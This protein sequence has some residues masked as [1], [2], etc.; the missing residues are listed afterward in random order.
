MAEATAPP[1]TP[2]S[3]AADDPRASSGASASTEPSRSPYVDWIIVADEAALASLATRAV[4][5]HKPLLV[6]LHADWC[7]PCKDLR[8]RTLSDPEVRRTLATRFVVARID[9]TDD[10][11]A[12][13]R[14]R[15]LL[16]VRSLPALRAYAP[17]PELPSAF[18]ANEAEPSV[19]ID[20]FV[21][22]RVLLEVLAPLIRR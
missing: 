13:Q 18:A 17:A 22:P 14:L 19:S 4:A 9:V 5:A 16:R 3:E 20:T 12:M 11:P 10:T 21:E 1:T 6:E 7:V 15:T 2:A 8:D